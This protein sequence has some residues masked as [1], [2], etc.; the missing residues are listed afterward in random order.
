MSQC[1]KLFTLCIAILP[2]TF[3]CNPSVQSDDSDPPTDSSSGQDSTHTESDSQSDSQS[4][5]SGIPGCIEEETDDTNGTDDTGSEDTNIETATNSE[6]E[7]TDF[8]T[9]TTPDTSESTDSETT[10]TTEPDTNIV[11]TDSVQCP[12]DMALV[13]IPNDTSGANR[14]CIDRYEASKPDA[15][16][17]S[18]G[19]DTSVAM[20]V[21]GV[22]PWVVNPMSDDAL[23]SFKNACK[24]AGKTLCNA[25]QWKATCGGPTQANYAFGNEF[26]VETCNNVATFC[27]DYCTA[28]GIAPQECN[29]TTSNC[30]YYCGDGSTSNTCFQLAPTGQFAQCT[31]QTGTF[32]VSGNLWEIVTSTNAAGY[33]I[34]GGAFNCASPLN[35]L[36]CNYI[37]NWTALYAGFRCCSEATTK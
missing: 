30:G 29:T 35:R 2:T 10:D 17:S 28:N 37:A 11:D 4:D 8:A 22:L 20:S 23:V 7:P 18:N 6:T 31:N 21:S 27:D 26:N 36:K 33:E 13:S 5:S 34:R 12:P 14:F 1:L 32:D 19:S 24:A 25:T 9:D 3:G 15:T 16:A